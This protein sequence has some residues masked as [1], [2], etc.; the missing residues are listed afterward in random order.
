MADTGVGVRPESPGDIGAI[1]AVN[2]AAFETSLEADLVDALRAQASPVVSLVAEQGGTI[3]GHILFSPVT[4]A[5]HPEARIGGLAPMAVA[6]Q[7]QRR[8]IG[9]ALVRAGLDAC[10]M[11]D[12][13]VVLGHADFYPRF[14]FVPASRFGLR[15]EYDVP[16]EVFMAHELRPGALAG[17][18]GTIRY[19]PA[20]DAA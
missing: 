14:G 13:V 15:C 2:L 17:K 20:F 3:V 16:D 19:H 8:G 1:R 6:P 11:F 9:S 4:L 5:D 10:A 18:R 7:T 12:A